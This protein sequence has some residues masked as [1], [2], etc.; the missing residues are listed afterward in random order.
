MTCPYCGSWNYVPL[1]SV[2]EH[3]SDQEWEAR[4]EAMQK[5]Y[6]TAFVCLECGEHADEH[7]SEEDDNAGQP[8]D[9]MSKP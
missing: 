4:E 7:M 3:M 8:S 5:G 6:D 2:D 1:H 9:K